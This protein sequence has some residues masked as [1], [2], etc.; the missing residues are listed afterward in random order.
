VAASACCADPGAGRQRRRQPET[1]LAHPENADRQR[2]QPVGQDRLV[3]AQL[4]IQVGG[5]EVAA[6]EHLARGLAERAFVEV[7]QRKVVQPEKQ[8][9]VDRGGRHQL[10]RVRA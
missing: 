7:E 3:E 5:D 10:R 9:Q 1:E 2:L 8:A 4:A 6:L